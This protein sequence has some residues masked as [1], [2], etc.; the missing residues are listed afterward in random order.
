MFFVH[1]NRTHPCWGETVAFAQLLEALS[2]FEGGKYL[3][4]SVGIWGHWNPV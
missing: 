4:V 1:Q 3:A 2:C